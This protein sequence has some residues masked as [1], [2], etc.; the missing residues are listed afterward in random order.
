MTH[1]EM[2]YGTPGLRRGGQRSRE[3]SGLDT[4]G[5]QEYIKARLTSPQ[6]E[7]VIGYCPLESVILAIMAAY[8]V[9]LDN[10]SSSTPLSC[11]LRQKVLWVEHPGPEVRED[12]K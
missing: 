7:N 1:G 11:V 4:L 8:K 5:R 10:T 6:P 12:Q 9:V 3:A 2:I